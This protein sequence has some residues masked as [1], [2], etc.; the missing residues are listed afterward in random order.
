M[1]AQDANVALLYV[2]TGLMAIAAVFVF[3]SKR[4]HDE[5]MQQVAAGQ[6]RASCATQ[7]SALVL[8]VVA[9]VLVACGVAVLSAMPYTG[10]MQ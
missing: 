1:N 6:K 3:A 5:P 8:V 7:L 4:R 9:L 2:W 10:R